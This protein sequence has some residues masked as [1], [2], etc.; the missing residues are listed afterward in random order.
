MLTKLTSQGVS[1]RTI[2]GG[3]ERAEL[4]KR[5]VEKTSEN[6]ASW[7]CKGFDDLAYGAA[8]H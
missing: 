8:R 2:L 5:C 1:D 3:L 7:N 6:D 4:S